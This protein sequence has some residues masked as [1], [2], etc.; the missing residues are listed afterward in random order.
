LLIV[1]LI[2][3]PPHPVPLWV[4]PISLSMTPAA[5]I[6]GGY[7]RSRQLRTAPPT[8]PVPPARPA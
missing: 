5:I 1:L 6:F 3:N 7:L 4:W 8:A 2:F